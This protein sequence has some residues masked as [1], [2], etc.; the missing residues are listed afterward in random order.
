MATQTADAS[1]GDEKM[2]WWFPVAILG[3]VGLGLM[4]L[5]TLTGQSF[6]EWSAGFATGLSNVG[7]GFEFFSNKMANS[8]P[9]IMMIFQ[10]G[11]LMV[12]LIWLAIRAFMKP[13]APAAATH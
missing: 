11:I 10:F 2:K 13:K 8:R 3:S 7:A 5:F 4:L 12:A 1:H 9:G 6:A